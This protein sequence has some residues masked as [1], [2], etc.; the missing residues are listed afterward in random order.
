MAFVWKQDYAIG[1]PKIDEQHKK[2]F[3]VINN[4]LVATGEGRAQ[5]EVFCTVNFLEEYGA[6]HFSTEEELM[7]A[8]K[9]PGYSKHKS[10]HRYFFA[11]LSEIKDK[12]AA[13]G[14]SISTVV[15][16]QKRLAD[17]LVVHVMNMDKVFGRFLE[18]QGK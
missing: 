2:L 7:V 8:M 17:W 12:L 9:Y 13:E 11:Q 5:E 1:V 15:L 4:L 16:I 14:P 3:E 6:V 10:E 18:D